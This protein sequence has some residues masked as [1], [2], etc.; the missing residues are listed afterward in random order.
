M[1]WDQ[2]DSQ[3]QQSRPAPGLPARGAPAASV[4]PQPD[5]ALDALPTVADTLFWD[6][7]G[8][9]L[10]DYGVSQEEARELAA[11]G[12]LSDRQWS[13]WSRVARRGVTEV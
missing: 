5:G 13:L 12:M 10:Q 4:T 1:S 3:R 8:D 2:K 9:P 7:A 6:A 11:A